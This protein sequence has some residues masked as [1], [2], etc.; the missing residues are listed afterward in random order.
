MSVCLS[1]S[2]E[3]QYKYL[4]RNMYLIIHMTKMYILC[5]FDLFPVSASQLQK[6][7][8]SWAV[9]AMETSFVIIFCLCP[10]FLKFP[11]NHEDRM[12]VLLFTASPF[13]PQLGLFIEVTFGKNQRKGAGCQGNQPWIQ[14]DDTIMISTEGR[15]VR[16]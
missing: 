16:H 13:P 14:C 12:S 7:I 2:L 4:K 6:L 8:I 1:P 9:R 15:D 11:Q 3:N 5:V 10:Q